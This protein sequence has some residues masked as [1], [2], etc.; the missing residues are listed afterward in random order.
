MAIYPLSHRIH[1]S[2]VERALDQAKISRALSNRIRVRRSGTHA[3]VVFE[4]VHR[5]LTPKEKR[6]LIEFMSKE[7]R[8]EISL[9]WPAYQGKWFVVVWID[10]EL[11]WEDAG[12]DLW[13]TVLHLAESR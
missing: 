11:A 4:V 5:G 3:R 1:N 12:G 9:A 7:R 2:S 6:T 13:N 10:S 8:E